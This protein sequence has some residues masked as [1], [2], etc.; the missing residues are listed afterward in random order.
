MMRDLFEHEAQASQKK[1]LRPHQVRAIEMIRNSLARGNQTVV[2]SMPTGAGKTLTATKIIEMAQAKGNAVIFTAPAVSLIDQTVAAFRAE[3]IEDIGVMQANHPLTNPLARVQVASVQ[4]LARR[5]IPDASLVI[6]DE[7]FV[8]GTMVAMAD[9]SEKPIEEIRLGDKVRNATGEGSVTARSAKPTFEIYRIEFEDGQ[10]VECTGN[11][12]FFTDKGWVRANAL[13][14]GSCVVGIE[15]MPGLWDGLWA[16]LPERQGDAR[17]GVDCASNLLSVL[18]KEAGQSVEAPRGRCESVA[19]I[20]AYWAQAISQ[21]RQWQRIDRT[22]ERSSSC[23]RGRVGARACGECLE[24]DAPSGNSWALQNRHSEP[25]LD[26]CNRGGWK[27]PLPQGETGTGRPE[28][29]ILG[30]GRVV[31]VS[32]VERESAV[33]VYNLQVSGHPSYFA[34]GHLVHNC[35]IRAEVIDQLIAERP[36]VRFVGLSATPW[37]KGMG[38]VWRDLVVPVTIADLIEGGLLSKFTAFAPDVPDLSGVKVSKGEYVESQLAEL[39]GEAKLVGH[40]VENWLAKG[41]N[42]PT[43]CFGVNCNH[44]QEMAASF[45]RAGVASAYVDAFTDTV[46]RGR[47]NRKFRD[48]E[49]RVICS[50]RTMTTG[51]DLPVSCIVDAAPTKSEMLHI[52]KLGRG[53]RINPG[54]EDLVIFDH[55]GNLLRLGM[56]DEISYDRLDTS[57]PGERQERKP[58][59]EKL[60][61]EC[62]NCAALHTGKTCPFCGHERNPYSG[63]EGAEGELVQI[64]GKI[65]RATMEDKQ[66]FYSMALHLDQ[67]RGRGGKLALGLYKGKF[68]VWPRGLDARPMPPDAAFYNYEKSRRIAYAK[69]MAK[70]NRA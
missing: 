65:K 50:V 68:G 25:C 60:P 63:I 24:G 20:A 30:W 49:V 62:S 28:V 66:R 21:R 35:H 12:P 5:E 48:G 64:R 69:R 6:V 10:H 32:R 16:D 33:A 57:K 4:T 15:G 13:V 58:S 41:E 46:Q 40:V 70:E 14:N 31:G 43:L 36:D 42:R 23:P 44:A 11:H 53:L 47:I 37:R 2:C 52:Q 51:V 45:E 34:G 8:A 39:M 18:L 19:D 38:L 27:Q 59:A 54:T 29:S 67:S 26:D 7:C 22:A 61:K 9:G 55:A 56:P 17:G 3:G 1:T